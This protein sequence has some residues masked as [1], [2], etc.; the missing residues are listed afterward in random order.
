MARR[1]RSNTPSFFVYDNKTRVMRTVW[2]EDIGALYDGD[3]L[4]VFFLPR[5]GKDIKV[6]AAGGGERWDEVLEWDGY[7]FVPNDALVLP[8][9]DYHPC[10]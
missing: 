10:A 3:G 9:Y 8:C 4:S 2:P 7:Q 5:Q 1:R 6:S